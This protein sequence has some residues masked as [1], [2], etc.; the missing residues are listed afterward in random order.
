MMPG[1]SAVRFDN[2]SKRYGKKPGLLNC[3]MEIPEGK[4]TALIG[5]NGAGKTTTIKL[6]LGFLRPT[7][8]KVLLNERP[9]NLL[10]VNHSTGYL[11]ESLEFPELYSVRQL[12]ES[13]AGIRGLN[14]KEADEFLSA[15]KETF[16][17]QDHWNKT[18]RSCS[19]GTRQKIGIIQTFMHNPK[20]AVLDE[21]TTGLDPVVRHSFFLLLQEQKK[22]GTSVVISSHNLQEVEGQAD[23]YLLFQNNKIIDALWAED[24]AAKSRTCITIGKDIPAALLNQ[25]NDFS[26]VLSGRNKILVRQDEYINDVLTLLKEVNVEVKDVQTGKTSLQDYFL[27][28]LMRGG[29][30]NE[31]LLG[32]Q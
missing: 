6:I 30:S 32:G 20:L 12:F 1:G 31:N 26:A 17:L 23:R 21:P 2:V 13:L 14:K 27:D 7:V 11:P 8:G 24:I 29:K 10:T 9:R 5:K 3:D 25:L 18:I 19:K 4:I 16:E 22:Q 15:A 28:T